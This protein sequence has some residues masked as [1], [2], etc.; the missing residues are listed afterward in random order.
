M[1]YKKHIGIEIPGLQIDGKDAPYP[2][3]NERAIRATAGIMMMFALLT[4]FYTIFAKEYILIRILII[5]FFT[6]FFIKVMWGPKYSLISKMGAWIVRKQ[7]P[8]YVWAVQ[9]RF[10]WS[11]GLFMSTCM[12]FISVIF[13]I[14]GIIPLSFCSTCIVLMWL[15]TSF[16]ICVW[17]KIYYFLIHK[18]VIREPVHRPAC[19]GGT[20][21]IG[22]K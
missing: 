18:G 5:V 4:V 6:D 11:L 12:V 8:E 10:A 14:T 21:S 22:R 15:E 3:L 1:I 19:P 2:V 9:K 16:G 20:C 7:K 17:C 13:G